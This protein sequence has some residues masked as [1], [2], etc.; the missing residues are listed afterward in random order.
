M[1]CTWLGEICSCCCLARRSKFHQTTYR[2]YFRALYCLTEIHK[3]EYHTSNPTIKRAEDTIRSENMSLMPRSATPTTEWGSPTTTRSPA[4]SKKC[5][6]KTSMGCWFSWHWAWG[7]Q[8]AL[9]LQAELYRITEIFVGTCTYW[10][11]IIIFIA[12]LI[13]SHQGIRLKF[14]LSEQH[15]LFMFC[16]CLGCLL[17]RLHGS[18]GHNRNGKWSLST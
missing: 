18:C 2:P 15:F 11:S 12:F 3:T 8:P 6:W 10:F 14:W 4:R 5:G 17:W 9:S 7:V 16:C 13:P 1:A